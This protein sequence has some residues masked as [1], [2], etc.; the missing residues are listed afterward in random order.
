MRRFAVGL[1]CLLAVTV[2]AAGAE[3]WPQFRGPNSTGRADG[4]KL[5]TEIG[6]DQ[7]VIWKVALPPGHSSPAVLGDRIFLTAVR[8]K[9][10]LTMAFDRATGKTLWER[11]APYKE[12]EQIHQIGSHA[13]GTPATDGERVVTFFGSSG[14]LCYNPD[15]KL[16]WHIRMGP[17]KNI[18]GAGSSPIIVGD[19]VILNQDHD[20]DSFLL[21]VDK[22]TGKTVW[23]VDRSEFPVGYATPVIW[24]VAGKK[25]VVISGSLRVVG[26]DLET[27][28][29]LWTVR[30]MARAVHMTPTIGPDGT[31]YAAGWTS[32]GGDDDRFNVPAFPVMVA[33]QDANKNGTLERNEIP[34]GP[35]LQRFSMLDRDKDTHVTRAEYD[36]LKNVFDSAR[37][38]IIAI[39]PGGKGDVSESHVM[40]S[41][42]RYLPVIPSP[43]FYHGYLY[44]PKN[45]GILTTLDP[46]TG[47]PVKEERIPGGSGDYYS[48]PVGGDGKVY[49]TSQRGNLVVLSAEGD[50]KVLHRV[51]FDEE[52]Y[53]TPALVDGRIYYR[54]TGYLY[55]FG[56]KP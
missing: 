16:L 47:E 11:E 51:R 41:Q 38:R 52:V 29:E 31:L 40:W 21:A 43:L 12:L 4:Y 17:F 30:G 37:N 46:K 9:T 32:G 28:K 56:E 24:E 1:V 53:A 8:D 26:Y 33:E 20:I 7:N 34:E 14:L 54:T 22:H 15:G 3:S 48:S 19:L 5:P 45:G 50:W 10:L 36:F 2:A 39:K 42:K 23:K 6:P 55:C 44:L 35:L 13:Q 27:G 49:L 18:L 25:Q